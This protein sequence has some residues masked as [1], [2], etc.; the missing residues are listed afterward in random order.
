[1]EIS[2]PIGSTP[3]HPGPL[4]RFIPPM[5]HG[6]IGQMLENLDLQG[7]C[8]L[9]PFGVS[10]RVPIEAAGAGR[11]VI[12][13]ANN[14]ISR[15][16]L[17]HT[18]KPFRVSE[19]QSALAQIAGLPK[20]D[21]RMENFIL[22][23]YR[24]R[25]A[26]CG[27]AVSVDFYVWDK[28][29]GGPSHKVYVCEECSHAGEVP[30]TEEDWERALDYS[31]R[32]L[33]HAMAVEQVAP[34]GDPD[35]KHAEAALAVY[36]GRAIYAI[37]TL[38]N[39][40]QQLKFNA[41]M[42]AA[43]HALLLSAFDAGN[44]LWGYP[45]GRERP[46]QLVA[47][48]RYREFNLWRAMEEAIG[49]WA[50]ED[51]GVDWTELGENVELAPGTIYIFHGGYSELAELIG[52]ER[53]DYALTVPPRPNQAFWTLSALWAAWLWGQSAAAPVKVA[54]RRRRYDWAWHA[55]AL[56]TVIRQI[57]PLL[58][59]PASVAAYLPESEPGFI[60]ALLSSLDAL[61][62]D[63][64]GRAL[65]AH[66]GHAA[67]IWQR[68]V[69]KEGVSDVK[70]GEAGLSAACRRVLISRCEP[71]SF[72]IV[73]AAGWS[74]LSS[75]H[76]P[77]A[78][79]ES[80]TR[81][82][83]QMISET[84]GT[85]LNDPEE[86]QRFGRGLE[87]ETGLYWVAGASDCGLSLFDRVE[88]LVL[89]ELRKGSPLS[90]EGADRSVCR[91]LK[92]L[93]TP[94]RRLVAAALQSYG[95]SSELGRWTLRPEDLKMA[96]AQDASEIR[97]DL[98]R[99]GERLGFNVEDV[100]KVIWRDGDEISF[101][102]LIQETAILGN[103]Q[104]DP[105]DT[106]TIA[107]PGGRASLLAEKSRRD[108]RIRDWLESGNRILKY[109]HVRRLVSESTLTRENLFERLEIDP[110]EHQDPQLPLL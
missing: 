50:M 100:E 57:T 48:Q 62:Y 67:A 33:H 26:R 65:R 75:K 107:M 46:R 27:A 24:S 99:I 77:R 22:D 19:L 71:A 78:H 95:E 17:E 42:E 92:G 18:L 13:I 5:D 41:D 97:E 20:D 69:Q 108:P 56:H 36:P 87:L 103:I 66:E 16:V 6:V 37:T 3:S 35:R 98:I 49:A 54:L 110:P 59:P 10:P 7:M 80:D 39:K 44:A 68:A 45:D 38:I 53:L 11:S 105:D 2:L 70:I 31:R 4:A 29:L 14:P 8:L 104:L 86:F 51:P 25:C 82:M 1:M 91:E 23:L 88:Q 28:E 30:T 47:S 76:Y 74:Y 96:R 79:W 58:K 89:D 73:H 43:V 81:Q 34:R 55:D 90:L 83:M 63:L 93:Q 52:R 12:V 106:L 85:V 60:A 109:R 94:G 40:V 15:F 72:A 32:G 84:L 102:F 9:D 61:G 101:R 64:Q 21:T